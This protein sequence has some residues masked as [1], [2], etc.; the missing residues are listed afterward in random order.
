MLTPVSTRWSG[1]SPV[2]LS[3][4][5][6][7]SAP[8]SP[9]TPGGDG[10]WSLRLETPQ[11]PSGAP[12]ISNLPPSRLSVDS[13]HV[14]APGP[15]RRVSG[16]AAVSPRDGSVP[17]RSTIGLKL[18]GLVVDDMIVGSPAHESGLKVGDILVEADGTKLTDVA[19]ALHA[20]TTPDEPGS[21]NPLPRTRL[22]RYERRGL[23]LTE[24]SLSIWVIDDL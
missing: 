19:E 6:A 8:R 16:G 12:A 22:I 24:S 9:V 20:L 17:T 4:L 14:R 3:P 13:M 1:Q 11:A 10:G 5:V 7:S 23:C 15:S 18:Q 2:D 21:V